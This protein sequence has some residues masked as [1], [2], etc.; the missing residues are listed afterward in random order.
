[1]GPDQCRRVRCALPARRLAHE[2]LMAGVVLL[3]GVAPTPFAAIAAGRLADRFGGRRPALV[4]LL[5]NAIALTGISLA[6]ASKSY[7]ALVAPFLLWGA[8][9]PFLVP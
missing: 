9:L 5:L 6:I 1:M 3:A 8:T 4:G 2:P 7:A